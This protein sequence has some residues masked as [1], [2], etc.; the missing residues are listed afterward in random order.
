MNEQA[1]TNDGSRQTTDDCGKKELRHINKSV[2]EQA[3]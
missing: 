2:E 3:H 1:V